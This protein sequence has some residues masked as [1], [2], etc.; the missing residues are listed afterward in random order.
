M[1]LD[2]KDPVALAQALIRCE[3]VTPAEGGALSLLE[4]VLSPAGFMCHRM[5]FHEAGTPDVENLYARRGESG[6]PLRRPKSVSRR[7]RRPDA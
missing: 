7:R 2:P 3:S 5:T 1:H 4:S 6:L